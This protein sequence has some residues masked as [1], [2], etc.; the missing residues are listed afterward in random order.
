[1]VLQLA[2]YLCWV[3]GFSAF[4]FV[5]NNNHFGDASQCD[6]HLCWRYTGLAFLAVST[7]ASVPF[8]FLEVCTVREYGLYHS[9]VH[10]S[11]AMDIATLTLQYL[12]LTLLAVGG[13][14][15]SDRQRHDHLNFDVLV[16]I[17]LLLLWVRLS[18][19]FRYGPALVT[20]TIFHTFVNNLVKI[21]RVSSDAL[22]QY[23]YWY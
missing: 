20:V 1:M 16:A 6:D 12:I 9:V 10:M 17:H 8:M 18:Q 11:G 5:L 19:F 3:L 7:L 15:T 22:I 13:P 21:I 23:H 14:G 4:T 2:V